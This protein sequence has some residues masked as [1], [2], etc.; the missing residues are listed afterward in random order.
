MKL[1]N[2]ISWKL[3]LAILPLVAVG[4]S[5]V[6]SM[7]YIMT[8]RQILPEIHKDIRAAAERGARTIDDLLRQRQSDLLTLSETPLIADYYHNVE[9]GL[10]DEARTYQRE[11]E[12]YFLHFAQ[13]S[14]V[15]ARILYLDRN[16]REVCRIDRDRIGPA[17]RGDPQAPWFA[18]AAKMRPGA[19]WT[20][21][22]TGLADGGWAVWYAKP[23]H[24]ETGRLA[25]VLALCYELSQVD[26]VLKDAKVGRTGRAF[27]RTSD[28]T[29]PRELG[30]VPAGR[31]LLAGER[32][33]HGLPWTL[34]V[35]A[36]LDEFLGPLR[37]IR[38][39]AVFTAFLGIAALLAVLL[40]LVR[41]ITR[42]VAALADAA[43]RIGEGDLAHRIE[44]LGDDELGALSRAFNEM[45]ANL[46]AN[47]RLNN[48]LQGQLIQAEK[49]SAVGQ[50][51]SSVAHELNNPLAA[52]Y[53]GCQLL[54]W[55]GASESQCQE[56]ERLAHNALRC[57]KVVDSLLFFVRRSRGA[58]ERID[59][60]RAAG[61]A[62]EL[63]DYRLKKAEDVTV[64]QEL[65][66]ALRETV[67][68]FQQFVQVL[69]NLVNNACD[70][71]DAAGRPEGKRLVLR[72][73]MEEGWACLSVAD[74]GSGIPAAA[75]ERVFEAFFTTK[76][77]G[78][79]TGLGLPVCKQIVEAH[80]GSISFE[81]EEGKGTC[82]RIALPAAAQAELD[83]LSQPPA[84]AAL[85]PV[86]GKSVLVVDDEPDVVSL[87]AR[88][89]AEDGDHPDTATSGSE[90]LRLIA[91]TRYDLVITDFSMEKVK[92]DEV[93]ARLKAKDPRCRVLFV[94]G[95]IFN[96][97]VLSFLDRTK[98]PYLVKPFEKGELQ[99]AVRR[100]LA[101]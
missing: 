96:P 60:N 80:G 30:P 24:D 38:N 93:F 12:R 52:V 26:T 97:R 15:Y 88:L 16:G 25:G 100:L 63:L 3:L 94:T 72:T 56:L 92:G 19:W 57:R 48:D 68:D 53:A 87:I 29:F 20:S 65:D 43:R 35:E 14:L 23:V 84:A 86:P 5:A 83:A 79:G 44:R 62:L 31:G 10:L 27:L 32:L 82:F 75:R 17:G 74:N 81:T 45:A 101:S 36:P 89:V 1:P 6:V 76:E 46:E 85:P 73:A 49:L 22:M 18:E 58:K 4:I 13:R 33:L 95:D 54:A 77:P 99:Q 34:V 47:R 78:R 98:S 42:P 66:P 90:A 7:Q 71:M 69:V 61:S 50:L 11:L 91:E 8:R 64:V 28:G 9:Y 55:E 41:S 59:L 67:G 70:A 51:V 37:T 39:A 2:K 40:W 21:P